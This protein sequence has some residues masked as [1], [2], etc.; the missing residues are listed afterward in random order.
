[1]ADSEHLN[2]RD[3]GDLLYEVALKNLHFSTTWQGF[4]RK[5]IGKCIYCGATENLSDEHAVPQ[6]LN[7]D[8]ILEKASCAACGVITGRFEG[9]YT[10]ETIKA[11]RAVL[12]MKTRRKKE[13]PKEFPVQVRRGDKLETINV[14]LDEY[15][16]VI[17]LFDIGPPGKYH[18]EHHAEGLRFGEAR[19]KVFPIRSEEE[20][21]KL[22]E[23]YQA[24]ELQVKFKVYL[25][26]FLKMIAKIA[27]C[28]AVARYG[29]NQI[30]E[31]YVLPAIIGKSNDIWHWVGGDGNQELFT[32]SRNIVGNHVVSMGFVQG[33]IRVRLKLFKDAQTPEY[34]VIVGRISDSVRGLYESVGQ[35]G[36]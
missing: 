3:K 10:N 15:A 24:D 7:G 28:F 22:A 36:A 5:Y 19:L 29:L 35:K 2:K 4:I 30:K 14:H 6:S 8:L 34:Y 33:E 16:A 31:V 1:M 20:T 18:W 12:G 26:D 17:P 13:R 23:K 11:A 9:R 25:E 32:V 21:R 27:Y